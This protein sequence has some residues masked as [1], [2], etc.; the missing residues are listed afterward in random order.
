[1]SDKTD[2]EQIKRR[3]VLADLPA[4]GDLAKL[5]HVTLLQLLKS[6]SVRLNQD[7]TL[8]WVC[9]GPISGSATFALLYSK[10][11]SLMNYANYTREALERELGMKGAAYLHD[12]EYD[13]AQIPITL[14]GGAAA[15]ETLVT[16]VAG[17]FFSVLWA[18]LGWD[19]SPGAAYVVDFH[20]NAGGPIN[21]GSW[22]PPDA[23]KKRYVYADTSTANTDLECSVTG[24]AGI[25][26]L[27]LTFGYCVWD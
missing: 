23:G 13:I 20:E 9:E 18:T 14:A 27:V 19:I 10:V 5:D 22:G 2:E 24:G 17:D 11:N 8:H 12:E 4:E 25:E 15:N 3:M 26:E 16:A 7:G 1:M 21:Y 6:G